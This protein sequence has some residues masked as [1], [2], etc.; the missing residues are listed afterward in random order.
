MPDT[1]QVYNKY[2]FGVF[3]PSGSRTILKFSKA[4]GI[5]TFKDVTSYLIKCIKNFSHF[6]LIFFAVKYLKGPFLGFGC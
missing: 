1:E 5:L 6:T 4:L 2:Y 3:I